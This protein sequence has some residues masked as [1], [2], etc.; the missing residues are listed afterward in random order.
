[1]MFFLA[2]RRVTGLDATGARTF[3]TLV[4]SLSARGV[5]TVFIDLPTSGDASGT[6]RLLAAHGLL[7]TKPTIPALPEAIAPE[8]GLEGECLKAVTLPGKL[9][10]TSLSVLF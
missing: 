6:R 8:L 1:M 3:S 2:R 5:Q 9:H 10:L 7:L 4:T